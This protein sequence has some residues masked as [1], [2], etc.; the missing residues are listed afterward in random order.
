MR[1]RTFP[2]VIMN[3]RAGRARALTHR[4]AALAVSVACIAAALASAG[5]GAGGVIDPVA[6]AASN[7]TRAAGYRL[8]MSLR[9]S[10]SALTSA[11]TA[12]GNGAFDVRARTGSL[13]MTMR[14]PNVPQITQQL[15]PEFRSSLVIRAVRSGERPV[16][17]GFSRSGVCS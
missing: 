8:S 1:C 9:I 15:G 17:V 11:I 4:I 6:T 14:L 12:T 5:C 10:S 13:T 7:T 2:P 16:F 3:A